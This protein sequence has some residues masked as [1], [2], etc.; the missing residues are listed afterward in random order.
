MTQE[1]SRSYHLKDEA[2]TGKSTVAS[3][4]VR[5]WTSEDRLGGCLFFTKD[6]LAKEHDIWPSLATSI[7]RAYATVRPHI[8]S[9]L[10]D[11]SSLLTDTPPATQ[12]DKLL[13]IPLTL[14]HQTSPRTQ[15]LVIVLDAVDECNDR[16][17]RVVL[18]GLVRLQAGPMLKVLA[19][20]RL[21]ATVPKDADVLRLSMDTTSNLGEGSA[22]TRTYIVS[23]LREIEETLKED[24]Q[25]EYITLRDK[26]AEMAGSLF[27]WAQVACDII[28]DSVDQQAQLQLFIQHP[29]L[30]PCSG[31]LLVTLDNTICKR[32]RSADSIT[33]RLVQD[34]FTILIAGAGTF[35]VEALASLLG[36]KRDIIDRLLDRLTSLL[37][38]SPQDDH[39]S[40][41]FIHPTVRELLINK[42]CPEE[43][44]VDVNKGHRL[45]AVAAFHIMKGRLWRNIL[46]L[47]PPLIFHSEISDLKGER[48]R[49][50]KTPFVML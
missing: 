8:I 7:Q 34:L 25:A 17:R 33:A 42:S 11:D 48:G 26:F 19:T 31:P 41:G 32:V 37:R 35:S 39:Q 16:E 29:I 24:E 38:R 27:I 5:K 50:S 21:E 36:K 1:E 20:S 43:S 12:L 2:G 14:A 46:G 22:D 30:R 45:S 28:L 47:D 23:R 49:A 3:Y 15:P 9:A 44:R 18:Q 40:I 4:C 6:D 10:G 13:V